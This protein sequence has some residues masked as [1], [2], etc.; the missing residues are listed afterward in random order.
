MAELGD[1]IWHPLRDFCI[2]CCRSAQAIVD[3]RLKCSWTLPAK[4]KERQDD[5]GPR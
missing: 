5:D 4:P 1:H 3:Y 2:R